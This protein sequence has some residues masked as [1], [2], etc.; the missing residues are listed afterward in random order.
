MGVYV[1]LCGFMGVKRHKSPI[2]GNTVS[3]GRN[4]WRA[5][6]GL[7]IHNVQEQKD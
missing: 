5:S 2:P 6:T 7:H 3:P 4:G 1:V